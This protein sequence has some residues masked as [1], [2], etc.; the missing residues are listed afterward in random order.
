MPA[1][2]LQGHACTGHGCYPPRTSVAG[3]AHF[4]VGGVPVHTQGDAWASHCCTV[5]PYPCHAGQLASGSP[6]FTVAGQQIGR[7][8]DPVDCGSQVA[9]GVNN[10]TV[11]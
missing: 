4:T 8:G 1:V 9:E 10:F 5:D 6:R 3:Q 2:T 11:A 7:V